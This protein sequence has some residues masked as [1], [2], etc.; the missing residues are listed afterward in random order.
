M[1]KV[2]AVAARQTKVFGALMGL[3]CLGTGARADVTET[4]LTQLSI[5]DLMQVKV[6]SAAKV[7]QTLQD[8]AA[9]VFVITAEDIRR[10]GVTT[11]PEVLRLAP[12]VE[13]ARINSSRWSVTIRGFAGTYSNKLLVLVDGRSIYTPLFSGVNWEVEGPPLDEISQ[14]EI[15]RGPGGS[16]WGANAVNGVINILTKHTKETEG[17]LVTL[18]AGNK[19]RAIA[20]V[21]YAGQLGEQARY[22][23]YGQFAE[24][25]GLVTATGHNAQDDWRLGKGGFRLDWTPNVLDAFTLQGEF[26]NANL[27]QNFTV[28]SLTAPYSTRVLSSVDASGGSL[29]ARW[30][31]QY[32]AQSK[33]ELQAYY[34]YEKH[35][36]YLY[37]ASLDTIDLDFQHSFPLGDR[38]GLV[39][40]LGYRR[41]RDEFADTAI[42]ALHP[43]GITTE[44]FSAFAQ[45]Q[46]DLI[47]DRFRLTVGTKLE[48]NDLTGW[49]WQPSLRALW[50][51]HPDHR[52]WASISHAVRTPSRGERDVKRFDLGTIAPSALTSNLPVLVYYSGASDLKSEE[53]TAYEIGYRG[54]LT[55]RFS[56]DATAFYHDY[57]QLLVGNPG[58]AVFVATPW[59][60]HLVLPLILANMGSGVKTGF[61]LAADWRPAERWQWR[62]AYSYLDSDINRDDTGEVTYTDGSRQQISLSG[63]WNARDDVD[64]DMR[65]RYVASDEVNAIVG[66]PSNKLKSFPE[67]DLRVG[68]R[69]RKGLELS[70]VG[71]NLLGGRHLEFVSEA[72]SSPVEVERSFYGQVKWKF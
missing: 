71:A 62:L 3:V 29:Q 45:D 36:D 34:H 37:D 10:S 26:Y 69:P 54:Q 60:P 15:V 6:V 27:K 58:T 2:K 8:T 49:E 61:E 33:M 67:L 23:L 43:K 64:V 72:L 16:L 55:K 31:R 11:I 50:T 7:E 38:Q 53:L 48:H 32:S 46:I 30:Q 68:W 39:W 21:R 51:L 40:G 17:G 41:N 1:G 20:S 4:D 57:T 59:S 65:W 19:E 9:A 24:R 25:D 12:G 35:N 56:L 47:P 18:T 42:T 52:L 13:V 28:Y 22:R 5:E 14:I 44:V 70:L 63:S 66:N